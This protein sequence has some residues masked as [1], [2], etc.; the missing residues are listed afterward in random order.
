MF[1]LFWY[2]VSYRYIDFQYKLY[3]DY[4]IKMYKRKRKYSHY[5]GM[6]YVIKIMISVFQCVVLTTL[7]IL[8]FYITATSYVLM[9][10]LCMTSSMFILRFLLDDL[11]IINGILVVQL[12]EFEYFVSNIYC[13]KFYLYF[14]FDVLI[15]FM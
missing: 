5:L 3:G 13:F 14:D 1:Y 7:K 15:H 2:H 11:G 10:L 8:K 6:S 12:F 9:S 4:I